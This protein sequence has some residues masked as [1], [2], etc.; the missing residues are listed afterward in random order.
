MSDLIIR[1]RGLSKDY[2]LGAETVRALRDVD[3]EI[4]PGE[5]VAVMGP[6][7]SGEV[8]LHEP[9]RVPGYADRGRLLA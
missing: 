5:F 4:R 6:S 2:I 1:T 9:D 8:H 3:I 7:G